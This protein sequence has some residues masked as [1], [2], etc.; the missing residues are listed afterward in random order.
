MLTP[1]QVQQFQRDGFL[2]G[3]RV[4]SDAEVD[5]LCQEM[6]RVL[7][8][9]KDGVEKVPGP[10][11]VMCCNISRDPT[12]AIW[13][14]VNIH[15][16]SDLF[17]RLVFHPTIAEEVA[18]LTEATGVR[19]WH[20]Q[21][22]YKPSGHGGVNYWHQDSPY[23]PVISRTRHVTA[24][25]ALD[26]VDE[27]N[28]CMSMVPGSHLWGEA[29]PFL[30][31]VLNDFGAMAGSYQGHAI[32]VKTCPVQ[33]GCVHFHHGMTWHGSNANRSGRK[34]RAIALHYMPADTR[35]VAAGRHVM[36]PFITAKD[37]EVI[38]DETFPL[39]WPRGN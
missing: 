1:A 16:A 25:V 22:Q 39:V 33:R 19:L 12:A 35:F 15:D 31:T 11:P 4:L 9:F 8:R 2:K 38:R 20:D 18:Q 26:D 5:T 3:S 29:G 24:W 37:G 30:R 23:W 14:V 28:G 10:K 13:Q 6:E 27:E 17:R 34:R 32:T 21:I 7:E 36:R